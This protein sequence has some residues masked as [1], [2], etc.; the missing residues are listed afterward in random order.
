ML[1]TYRSVYMFVAHGSVYTRL[2]LVC[3]PRVVRASMELSML[4]NSG[5]IPMPWKGYLIS[6][7]EC[8]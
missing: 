6:A 1:V 8:T 5:S 7:K 2:R 4:G 3:E